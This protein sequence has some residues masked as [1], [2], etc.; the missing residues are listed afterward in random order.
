MGYR[1]QAHVLGAV[2]C[3]HDGAHL[4]RA[5]LAVLIGIVGQGKGS[6]SESSTGKAADRLPVPMVPRPSSTQEGETGAGALVEYPADKRVMELF[7]EQVKKQPSAVALIPEDAPELSYAD[8]NR[9]AEQVPNEILGVGVSGGY[10]AALMSTGHGSGDRHLGSAQGRC[11][12]RA[13]G[14]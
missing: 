5:L 7:E 10:V 3:R 6:N 14:L 1:G 4:R 11:R 2:C 8:L 9:A 13:S 12:L